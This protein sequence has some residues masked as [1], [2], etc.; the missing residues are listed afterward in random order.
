MK[1]RSNLHINLENPRTTQPNNSVP[2]QVDWR[3]PY[4]QQKKLSFY[5][6]A[7]NYMY[8]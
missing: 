7:L 3:Y 8:I 6:D 5:L 1:S 2:V 4:K